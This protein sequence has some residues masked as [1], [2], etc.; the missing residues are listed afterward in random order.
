M[1]NKFLKLVMA[2]ICLIT[3]V[4]RKVEAISTIVTSNAHTSISD[5]SITNAETEYSP[6]INDR[7][8]IVKYSLS[9]TTGGDEDTIKSITIEVPKSVFNNR[10]GNSG[11]SFQISIPT[12]EEYDQLT[13]QGVEVDSPW[14]YEERGDKIFITNTKKVKVGSTYNIEI[15][16]QL[17]GNITEFKDGEVSKELKATVTIDTKDGQL[18]TEATAEDVTINTSANLKG[19]RSDTDNITAF[20]DIWNDNWGP[21]PTD[22]GDYYYSL[23]RVTSYITGSQPYNIS[24]NS[25]A[26]D[27]ETGEEFTPYMYNIGVNGWGDKSSEESSTIYEGANGRKDY[28]LYRFPK[29]T[30]AD[31]ERV[32]FTVTN[33]VTTQGIDRVDNPS[34]TITS[35]TDIKYTKQPWEPEKG[36][37]ITLQNGDNYYRVK[38]KEMEKWSLVNTKIDKYSRY[39]LQNFQNGTLSK[40]DG[41]DFGY[42]MYGMPMGHT[43]PN[44]LENKPSNYFKESVTYN[45]FI[46]GIS[47]VNDDDTVISDLNS[48]DYQIKNIS[49]YTK[50]LDGV[51]SINNKYVTKERKP[52]AS[53][54]IGVYAKYNNSNSEYVHIADYS[55]LNDTYSNVKNGIDVIGNKLVLDDNVVA[56]KLTTSNPYYYTKVLSGAEYMLK[57]SEKVDSYVRNKE[58]IKI[59]SNVNAELLSSTGRQIFE[60]TAPTEYDFARKTETISEIK[61]DVVNVRNNRINKRY[62]IIWEITVKEIAKL[63]ATEETPIEQTGGTWYDLMPAGLIV[64]E[65][66]VTLFDRVTGE[67]H[68]VSVSSEAN[69]KGT[70]RTLYKFTTTDTVSNPQLFFTTNFSYDGIRDYGDII[71]NPVAYE[72]GN[73]QISNGTAD[74]ARLTKYSKEMSKLTNDE[75]ERFIYAEKIY[76]LTTLVYFSSGLSKSIKNSTDSEYTRTTQVS[77]NEEYSYK[78]TMANSVVASSKDIVMFDSLEN[79]TTPSGEKS[80]WRG[81]LQSIDTTQIESMGIQPVVYASDVALDL[82]S[83]NGMTPD[84]MLAKFKPISE[85]TDYSTIKAIAIDC[86][87]NKD[88]T[89]AELGR[90]KSLVS[91][92]N[93][94]APESL[95]TGT[96]YKNFNNVYAYVTATDSGAETSAFINNGYTVNSYKVSGNM[97]VN[98]INSETKQGAQGVQFTLSGT[99]AYGEPISM[100]RTSNAKGIVE[101]KKIPV[102]KYLLVETDS[103]PNYFLDDTKHIV[104]VTEQGEVLIDGQARS[105]ITLENRPRISADIKFNKK[106]YPN[107]MGIS[108][109]V[110]NAEFTLQGTSDYGN[111]VLETAKSENDGIVEF[112]NIEKGTYKLFETKAPDAFAKSTDEYKVVINENG[113]VT[114]TNVTESKDTDTIYNYRRLVE[115]SFK[116]LNAE[117][118]EP[119]RSGYS[120]DNGISFTVSGQDAE[121]RIVNKTLWVSNN[122]TVRD[123]MPVGIYTVQENINPKDLD[124]KSYLRDAKEYILEV[125]KDGTFTLDMEKVGDDYVV[126]NTQIATDVITITKKWVGGN[127]E[128]Y[129]PKIRIYTN[130]NDI[131]Q[132]KNNTNESNREEVPEIAEPDE[133]L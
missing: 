74:K 27:D 49:V 90:G 87:T 6:I 105:A 75:G 46:N 62:E 113:M 22:S 88:G 12:R 69:Y 121:G 4:P 86:R 115:V 34:D 1:K 131:P 124:G 11:D 63:S 125:K 31:K 101:F 129:I 73:K 53:D 102:G 26:V 72:T 133:G 16:Y 98:K 81:I 52:V 28:I 56:Y 10:A 128:G 91:I 80:N 33:E 104:E 64:N 45:Q 85:F 2:V 15:G 66:T 96:T 127:P 5:F 47:L 116:K 78:L 13:A 32:K 36:N 111:D 55:P 71:Y 61:K 84:E 117:T 59:A 29:T 67:E 68:N 92:V 93:M 106:S 77:Q 122:G 50:Y 37:F 109:P 35:T 100:S 108:V 25:K 97:F 3:F 114:I 38:G 79:F 20:T 132:A 58:E 118:N 17:D 19:S 112:K 76:N 48:D 41:L 130:P 18:N 126:K 43:V 21:E 60:Y 89:K 103:T 9:L 65:D 30:Y 24:I 95:P 8:H 23:V 7:D 123:L 82:A 14:A 99:S 40:Y 44:G 107:S 83:M 54:V 70:G 51:L 120:A 94:K 57:H 110:P 119:I 39:D 42:Y